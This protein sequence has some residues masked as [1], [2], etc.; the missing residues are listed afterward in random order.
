MKTLFG[1]STE[2][3]ESAFTPEQVKALK[4]QTYKDTKNYLVTTDSWHDCDQNLVAVYSQQIANIAKYTAIFEA[5]EPEVTTSSRGIKTVSPYM[6][7]LQ[8]SIDTSM[9]LAE[10]LGIL[11]YSRK[12]IET[13]N[14]THS[15]DEDDEFSEFESK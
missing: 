14:S 2:P 11:N 4:N 1:D 7:L 13:M 5:G 3:A 6:I 9:K 10:K 8:K 15:S 12:R